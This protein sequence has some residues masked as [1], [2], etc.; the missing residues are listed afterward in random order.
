MNQAGFYTSR[1][2]LILTSAY[3][4]EHISENPGTSCEV[5]SIVRSSTTTRMFEAVVV[6]LDQTEQQERKV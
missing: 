4:A 6:V 2:I 1:P 5:G 3:G